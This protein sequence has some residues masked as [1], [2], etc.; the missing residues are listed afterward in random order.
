MRLKVM[1]VV[2]AGAN[3]IARNSEPIGKPITEI[4]SAFHGGLSGPLCEALPA[5]QSSAL[6][7][8]APGDAGKVETGRISQCPVFQLLPLRIDVSLQGFA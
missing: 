1:W 5:L 2:S 3:N 4:A 6:E 8:R 7:G